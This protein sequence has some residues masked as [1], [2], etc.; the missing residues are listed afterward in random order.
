MHVGL[1]KCTKAFNLVELFFRLF[2]EGI[3][4]CFRKISLL[5]GQSYS[6]NEGAFL[7]ECAEQ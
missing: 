6:G 3:N 5:S 4:I 7:S 2:T 1:N